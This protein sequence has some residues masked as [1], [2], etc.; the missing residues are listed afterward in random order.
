ML[1]DIITLLKQLVTGLLN[2]ME[3]SLKYLDTFQK[4]EENVHKL[5]D[6]ITADFLGL[7]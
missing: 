3:E 2:A 4:F 5:T 7:T 6:Q 1:M